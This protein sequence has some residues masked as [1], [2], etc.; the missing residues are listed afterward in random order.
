MT[1]AG[2]SGARAHQLNVSALFRDHFAPGDL[3]T[4]DGGVA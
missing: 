3:V 1:P 2:S 4:A